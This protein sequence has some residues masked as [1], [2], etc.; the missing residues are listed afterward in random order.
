MSGLDERTKEL[1][2]K[3]IL[4]RVKDIPSLPDAVIKALK[5]LNNPKSNA[6]DVAAVLSRDEGLTVR[7]LKLANSAYY[8][9]PRQVT[10]LSEAVAILGYKTVKSI[11]LAA[12]VYTYINKKFD[13]YALQRGDLW[14]HSL[15]VAVVSRLLAMKVKYHDP[16]E[17]FIAGMI[18]DIGKIVLNEYVKFGFSIIVRMVEEENVPFME[19]ERKVL[20]FDHA[21]IGAKIIEQWGLPQQFAAVAHYHHEP[22]KAP[23]EYKQLVNIV[24]VAN[25]VVLMLGIGVGSD[26]LLYPVSEEALSSLGIE[27]IEEFMSEAVDLLVQ[28]DLMELV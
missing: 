9:L 24:H 26:G 8:G 19:A 5:M 20:G 13:G 18:H 15:S 1:V 4:S 25:S 7:I 2:M 3:R 23:D 6:A 22:E 28:E 10:N 12:S 27:S 21:E 16:E 17:A 11:V 14:R